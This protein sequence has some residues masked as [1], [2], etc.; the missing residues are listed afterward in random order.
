MTLRRSI[1]EANY[2][3]F[4]DPALP[5]RPAQIRIKLKVT[6]IPLDPS[7]AWARARHVV[8]AAGT[9]LG[10]PMP[11]AHL[12]HNLAAAK[13]GN[14]LD[15]NGTAVACRSWLDTEWSEFTNRFKHSVEHS[16]NNQMIFLPT[17]SGVNG[18]ELS[19]ADYLQFIANPRMP[20]H[21]EGALEIELQP[22]NT[23]GH[24]LIEVAHLANPGA[25]FRQ[26]MSRISDES[27]LFTTS[28]FTYRRP[29]GITGKTGQIAAAHE[30]GHWLRDPNARLFEHIDRTF[31][32]TLPKAR[33]DEAQYGR[34][35]GR[36]Y[37]LMGGGSVVGD[38]EAAPWITRLRRQTPMKL[39]WTHVHKLHFQWTL[40]DIPERQ[41]QL[42]QK[43][44]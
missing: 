35:L 10:V 12:A 31:A 13:K 14:V 38:Y 19:D 33:Q 7:T 15:A 30:I 5:G 8:P 27:V 28:G 21:A 36:F 44:A 17:E 18:D 9:P 16:W 24:A 26:R 4:L 3:S 2:D 41:K 1:S 39:G 20:A 23:I 32:V 43:R 6:L 37:S 42:Q 11:P 34:T 25:D 40:D 22:P 29:R